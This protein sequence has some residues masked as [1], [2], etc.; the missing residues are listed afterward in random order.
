MQRTFS[1]CHRSRHGFAE[2]LL[3]DRKFNALHL[4]QPVQVLRCHRQSPV[5]KP[6][7]IL[8]AFLI[9]L[10]A[11]KRND[12]VQLGLK[13]PVLLPSGTLGIVSV[14]ILRIKS[15][16][17]AAPACT[18]ALGQVKIPDFRLQLVVHH[19]AAGSVSQGLE[20]RA[21]VPR[22]GKGRQIVL[23][24]RYVSLPET[25]QHCPGQRLAAQRRCQGI[26]IH[27]VRVSRNILAC[28]NQF[29]LDFIH[30]GDC[31][32]GVHAAEIKPLLAQLRII[33]IRQSM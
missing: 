29:R 19:I 24:Q 18:A 31:F 3:C 12:L 33:L 28:P 32:L 9:Y 17:V 14:H 4:F 30:N 26:H 20:F 8:A 7:G 23:G 16:S 11:G 2:T 1:L 21:Q 27:I 5:Q 25:V 13:F 15:G 10:P 6:C 22:L